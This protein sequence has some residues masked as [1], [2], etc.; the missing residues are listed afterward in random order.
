MTTVTITNNGPDDAPNTMV[1]FSSPDV[2]FLVVTASPEEG[3]FSDN[4]WY[5]GTMA[6][7]ESKSIDV[8]IHSEEPIRVQA[9]VYSSLPDGN[10]KNNVI[11][12]IVGGEVEEDLPPIACEPQLNLTISGPPAVFSV[13]CDPTTVVEEVWDN[14]E[15]VEVSF[16]T[17]FSTEYPEFGLDTPIGSYIDGPI[18]TAEFTNI[19]QSEFVS[20]G[21]THYDVGLGLVVN[22][23]GYIGGAGAVITFHRNNGETYTTQSTDYWVD[24][25]GD[26]PVTELGF[27]FAANE[28][29]ERV[30]VPSWVFEEKN[31]ACV[32]IHLL[33]PH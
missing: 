30:P 24:K 19:Y 13:N 16:V 14:D 26:P 12:F 33:M 1:A 28:P 9:R 22:L 27:M 32:E 6:N 18:N 8:T 11:E 23:S 7:G 5:V 10:F 29:S 3:E 31:R 25:F 21:V 2:G 4:V 17:L 20:G 15:L